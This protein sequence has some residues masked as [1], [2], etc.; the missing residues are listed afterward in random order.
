MPE[1]LAFEEWL[2]RFEMYLR[3][4]RRY[5]DYTVTG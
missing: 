5:S 2:R 3:F 4:E 1:S